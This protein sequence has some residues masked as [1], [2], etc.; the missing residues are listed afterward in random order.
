M[1]GLLATIVFL[2]RHNRRAFWLAHRFG[3][4]TAVVA[5]LVVIPTSV[6]LGI[7]DRLI[8]DPSIAPVV[9]LVLLTLPTPLFFYLLV[10]VSERP[11]TCVPANPVTVC[12]GG[13]SGWLRQPCPA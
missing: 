9:C 12:A 8:W 11:P 7:P 5:V 10:S 2:P 6:A 1:K 13:R 3:T 4:R